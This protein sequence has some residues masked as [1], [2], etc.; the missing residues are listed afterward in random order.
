MVDHAEHA[1]PRG[2]DQSAYNRQ[3]WHLCGTELSFGFAIW[4]ILPS[5]AVVQVKDRTAGFH[6][7][8]TRFI[9]VG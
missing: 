8:Y 4:Q 9:V 3:H 1:E 2:S 7:D 6:S 5:E